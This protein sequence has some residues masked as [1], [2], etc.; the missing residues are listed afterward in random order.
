MRRTG[1]IVSSRC[2]NDPVNNDDPKGLFWGAIGRFFKAIGRALA[3]FFGTRM[4]GFSAPDFRTPPTFP[5]SLPGID[6]AIR[7]GMG[8]F[9][10]PPFVGGFLASGSVK[11]NNVEFIPNIA[12]WVSNLL[13]AT[14]QPKTFK[15]VEDAAV[16]VLKSINEKSIKEDKEYEGLIC[17]KGNDYTYTPPRPKNPDFVVP[18]NCENGSKVAGSYHTHGALAPNN[19]DNPFES[20]SAEDINTI[21]KDNLPGYIAA[22]TGK[23]RVY[24]PRQGKVD[25]NNANAVRNAG[26]FLK[27]TAP[28]QKP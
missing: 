6:A 9:R 23:I 3:N 15:T 24:D 19:T 2:G 14:Q 13:L 16:D 10:T 1:S 20:F 8:G 22:P 26:R 21:N 28:A 5:G 11:L 18:M 7:S 27:A 12:T 25:P 17:R 4:G